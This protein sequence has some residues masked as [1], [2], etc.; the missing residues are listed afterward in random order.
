MLWRKFSFFALKLSPEFQNLFCSSKHWK[1]TNY[2]KK[3]CFYGTSE[4]YFLPHSRSQRI[5][6]KIIITFALSLIFH[7]IF[8]HPHTYTLSPHNCVSCVC[9]TTSLLAAKK[10]DWV[11]CSLSNTERGSLLR[12]YWNKY[13]HTQRCRCTNNAIRETGV[14]SGTLT[15]RMTS[16]KN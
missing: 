4:T 3:N 8:F 11:Q 2:L 15:F 10:I 9:I 14:L 6:E 16:D 13:T 7:H 12:K 1:S 5:T